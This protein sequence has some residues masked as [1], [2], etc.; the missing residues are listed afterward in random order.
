MNTKRL[1]VRS[2]SLFF[3]EL[4]RLFFLPEG[5]LREYDGGKY[6]AAAE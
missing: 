1:S 3:V 4:L 6:Q 5:Y 2:D